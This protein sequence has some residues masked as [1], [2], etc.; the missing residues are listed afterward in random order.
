[1]EANHGPKLP[2]QPEMENEHFKILKT[3]P[4]GFVEVCFLF[5]PKFL[6]RELCDLVWI[7]FLSSR[8]TNSREEFSCW[9]TYQQIKHSSSMSFLLL[10]S[11]VCLCS[12]NLSFVHSSLPSGSGRSRKNARNN[13]RNDEGR[14]P[15]YSWWD[16]I[17]KFFHTSNLRLLFFCFI[18]I[19]LTRPM[20]DS[21]HRTVL[22]SLEKRL[23]H[24]IWNIL[25]TKIMPVSKSFSTL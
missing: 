16:Y 5:Y 15:R 4:E 2:V 6:L 14:C 24:I 10:S 1:M 21:T 12:R 8:S 11:Y 9:R 7:W 19:F 18:F 13:Q 25:H 17:L 22:F 20:L 23:L 3:T